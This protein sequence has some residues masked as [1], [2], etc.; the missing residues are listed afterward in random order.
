MILISG[1]IFKF[2]HAQIYFFSRFDFWFLL[3]FSS[4]DL[5]EGRQTPISKSENIKVMEN[6]IDFSLGKW[7]SVKISVK[8][9]NLVFF[10]LK[11]DFSR[12]VF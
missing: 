7:N 5:L 8:V 6:V 2:V 12:L 4:F 3:R 9:L 1:K 11:F 10:S